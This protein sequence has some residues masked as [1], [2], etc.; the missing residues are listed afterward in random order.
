MQNNFF[1]SIPQKWGIRLTAAALSALLMMPAT[2]A[3]AKNYTD[4]PESYP[5]KEQIDVLSDIGVIVGS[6]ADK[7]SPDQKVT[8]E[9]MALLLFRLMLAREGAGNV[10]STAFTDLTDETYHGAISWANASG[11]IVGT[12]DSTFNPKG[13][14]TLQ[15][16][17]TMIVRALGQSSISADK[18][19]PWTYID[20]ASK[21]GLDEGL[22]SLSYTQ[23]LT[24]GQVAA[25]LYNALTAEY[26]IP[27][28]A[29]NGS[30]GFETTTVIEKV[31]GHELVK[32]T[33]VATNT[34]ALEG[35]TPVIKTGHVSFVM[36]DGKTMTVPFADLGLSGTP[37]QWLGKEIG[38]IRGE[39]NGA[40][41]IIGGSYTGRS[42]LVTDVTF[43]ADGRYL[44]AD[45]VRYRVVEK[46]SD[47]LSTNANELTVYL[48]SGK[49]QLTQMKNTAEL[50]SKLGFFTMEL[51]F[52]SG[53]EAA[54][55]AVVKNLSFGR[56]SSADGKIN[57][58]G[59]LTEQQLVGG[60]YNLTGALN[61]D[62]VLYHFNTDNKRL[63]IAEKLNVLT[64]QQVT[65]VTSTTATVGGVT[66][67]VGNAAA[68][69]SPD[70]LMAKLSVG[71]KVNIITRGTTILGIADSQAV[72]EQAS[73]LVLLSKPVPVYNDGTLRYVASAHV[74]G[75]IRNIFLSAN[76]VSREIGRVYRFREV[77][78]TYSLVDAS[79][80][81]FTVTGDVA[82]SGAASEATKIEMGKNAFFT[83]NGVNFV[84][85]S[86]TVILLKN[87]ENFQIH[88]GAFASSIAMSA[89]A[90]FTAIYHDE[91]GNTETLRFLYVDGGVIEKVESGTDGVKILSAL[92]LELVNDRIVTEYSVYVYATGKIENRY[93][94]H[95]DL[96]IG[97]SYNAEAGEKGMITSIPAAT[98]RGAVEGFTASTVTVD[99]ATY[100]IGADC[101][102]VRL[103]S[104]N[105]TVTAEA[106]KLEQLFGQ[107]IE[108][109]VAGGK[110]VSIL[111]G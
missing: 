111:V 22:E 31:F 74:G 76:D 32:G 92:G 66:Y 49:N 81:G 41:R 27:Y 11:Y 4:V 68:G 69:I 71:S 85:D 15:D 35:N 62:Y 18:G 36:A 19:Y 25:L 47:H 79:T 96:V 105:G 67:T 110:I 61:G 38:I 75:Q 99:G 109:T 57:L 86:G 33:M 90:D 107:V 58:A 102:I 51:L 53:A 26:R 23:A 8:R 97:N 77:N 94:N 42:K 20:M 84:T 5:Y 54:T 50:A 14:I 52:D 87:G 45:G 37:E 9:Q 108:F 78:G 70:A 34:L 2:V 103:V 6:S 12:S 101:M 104:A 72:S 93:S 91:V 39:K 29:P 17:F 43:S 82:N 48:N 3:F 73:Y 106:V 7:F 24:R 30:T 59:N 16:A 28:S 95:S 83:L 40:T 64:D 100:A 63:E 46:K 98:K 89:G 44:I 55:S 60:Y 56:L 13:E 88:T 21:L 80:P 10:N 65:K 1:K